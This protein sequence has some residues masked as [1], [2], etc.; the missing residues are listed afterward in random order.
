MTKAPGLSNGSDLV[1]A[2]IKDAGGDVRGTPLEPATVI[3]TEKF[4]HLRVSMSSPRGKKGLPGAGSPQSLCSQ[5]AFLCLPSLLLTLGRSRS[6]SC[7][8]RKPR[9]RS[10]SCRNKYMLGAALLWGREGFP[11]GPHTLGPENCRSFNFSLAPMNG[12]PS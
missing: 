12:E 3:E 4:R 1:N 6:C 5:V 10:T 11:L 2:E 8:W 9:R 7:S